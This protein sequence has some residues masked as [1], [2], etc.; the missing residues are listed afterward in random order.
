MTNYTWFEDRL[1]LLPKKKKEVDMKNYGPTQLVRGDQLQ[2]GDW[3]GM[4]YR[5]PNRESKY[6]NFSVIA[7]KT[8]HGFGWRRVDQTLPEVEYEDRFNS[9]FWFDINR[10]IPVVNEF[11]PVSP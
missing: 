6:G 7:V 8:K 5:D 10:R 1:E 2:E 9:T 3:I 4:A 11:G